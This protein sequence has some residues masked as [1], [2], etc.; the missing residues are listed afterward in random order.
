[1]KRQHTLAPAIALLASQPAKRKL[2]AEVLGEF[3]YRVVFASEPERLNCEQL[4]AVDPDAWLLELSEESELAEW[5]LEHSPVPV[6]LGTGEVPD[7]HSD[8][9]PRWKRRLYNKLQPLLGDPP[10]G[11][12]PSVSVAPPNHSGVPVARCVWLLAASL[13]GPAAVKSFLDALPA[14]LPVAFIYAQHIDAGFEYKLPQILGRHNNWRFF[15]CEE[16]SRLHEGEVMVAPITRVIEFGPAGEVRLSD[17]PWPGAYQPAI[18][19]LLDE[20]VKAF[21]PGCGAIIFS[22]MGEDGVN[23]CGRMHEKGMQVWT[24]NAESAACAT[25]PLAVQLAGYSSRQGS[26]EELAAAMQQWVDEEWLVAL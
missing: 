15:N 21:S 2:L 7:R 16:G 25:M 20:I 1:M 12:A 4:A 13:G 24:Q 18:E 10:E 22:G 17:Q 11:Q 26:P 14:D 3:G 23:A 8:D 19:V 9:Y 5:L 6:L